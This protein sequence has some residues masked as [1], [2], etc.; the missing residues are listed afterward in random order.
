MASGSNG[1]FHVAEVQAQSFCV[2][3]RIKKPANKRRAGIHE[4][5]HRSV[6]RLNEKKPAKLKAT[7][8]FSY[9]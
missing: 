8:V 1:E 6:S 5:F 2:G 3:A 7:R 9:N 4:L